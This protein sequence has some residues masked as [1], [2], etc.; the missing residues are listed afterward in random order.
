LGNP[1]DWDRRQIEF[2]ERL[3]EISQAI[4]ELPRTKAAKLGYAAA[5]VVIVAITVGIGFWLFR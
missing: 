3:S 2:S 1:P 4:R 5:A